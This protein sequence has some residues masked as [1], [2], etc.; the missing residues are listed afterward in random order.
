MTHF[1]QSLW[2]I[3]FSLLTHYIM[4]HFIESLWPI[5]FSLLNHYIIT[6]FIESLWPISFSL[7]THYI[8][9]HF[10]ESLWPISFSL[11]TYYIVTHFIDSLWPILWITGPYS[12]KSF[13]YFLPSLWHQFIRV[14]LTFSAFESYI[15]PSP[16]SSQ[17]PFLSHYDPF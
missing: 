3:S 4:T 2:P 15:D 1:I 14:I 8:M 10:I 17:T 6:H 5:S 7:L 13:W 12:L 9:T 16:K 11:L